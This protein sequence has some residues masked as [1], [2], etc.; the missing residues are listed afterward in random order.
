MADKLYYIKSTHRN[1]TT[2]W[3]GT[4]DYL[5]NQV[6]GYTLE[7]GNSW[8]HK[9]PRHP[10]TLGSLVNALNNSAD[11]CRRYSDYY[12]KSTKE[13]FDSSDHKQSMRNY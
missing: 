10:K 9:I 5:S 1:R 12:E 6:F 2:I 11:E 4:L 7:C 3:E 8:N 13:E